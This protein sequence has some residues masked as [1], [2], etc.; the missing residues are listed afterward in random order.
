M[1]I[2]AMFLVILL[3]TYN[4]FAAWNY[5]DAL[6]IWDKYKSEMKNENLNNQLRNAHFSALDKCK[7]E[8]KDKKIKIRSI[9]KV[10]SNGRVFDAWTNTPWFTENNEFQQCYLNYL[11]EMT[12]DKHSKE[13][14]LFS[15]ELP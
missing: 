13:F 8:I 1:R 11:R 12:F 14:Y 3:F 2:S 15:T 7:N 6:R 4:A 10:N 9:I 5:Y